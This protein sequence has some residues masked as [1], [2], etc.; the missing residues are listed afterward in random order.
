MFYRGHDDLESMG[1]D[2]RPDLIGIGRDDHAMH[3]LGLAR[4]LA[5]MNDEW[6]ARLG[7][8]GFGRESGRT[9]PGWDDGNGFASHVQALSS[10]SIDLISSRFS[11]TSR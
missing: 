1:L 5:N 9:E 11:R 7:C 10:V 2:G 8:E 3:G 4:L 6:L